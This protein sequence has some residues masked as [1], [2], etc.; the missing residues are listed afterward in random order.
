MEERRPLVAVI[1]ATW[2][3]SPPIV[4]A[5]EREYPEARLWQLL[6]DRLMAD[7]IEEGTVTPEL[8]DRLRRLVGHATA[9]GADAILLTCSMYAGHAEWAGDPRVATTPME[10]SKAT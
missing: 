7:A 6:D 2:T 5:F 9:G 4:D 8:R 10:P 3:A 1:H